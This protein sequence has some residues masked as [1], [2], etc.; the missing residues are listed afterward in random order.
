MKIFCVHDS[1]IAVC[2]GKVIQGGED[3]LIELEAPMT[4]SF[5]YMEYSDDC[6]R[7]LCAFGAQLLWL[8]VR[9]K[10]L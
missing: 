4:E 10:G 2:P 3:S 5:A 8:L 6:N 7:I 1:V 9:A